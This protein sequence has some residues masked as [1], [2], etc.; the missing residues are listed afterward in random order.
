MLQIDTQSSKSKNA[1]VGEACRRLLARAEGGRVLAQ[2]GGETEGAPLVSDAT[3]GET[4]LQKGPSTATDASV[5]WPCV[6][7]LSI[8][9]AGEA[10]DTWRAAA[11]L[12]TVPIVCLMAAL[13]MNSHFR[14]ERIGREGRRVMRKYNEIPVVEVN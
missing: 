6:L 5:G 1:A 3:S 8:G 10:A 4:L 2:E 9:I 13:W 11:C 7:K 12:D 14:E